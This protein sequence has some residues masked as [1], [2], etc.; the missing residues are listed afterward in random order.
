[1][2]TIEIKFLMNQWSRVW[3]KRQ[4]IRTILISFH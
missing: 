4:F 3:A 2:N 1:V